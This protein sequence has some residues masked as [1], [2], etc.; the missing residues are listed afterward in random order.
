M[1]AL[2]DFLLGTSAAL[3]R[4]VLLRANVLGCCQPRR[5]ER[6]SLN[7]PSWPSG[8]S[9]P[10]RANFARLVEPDGLTRPA[11]S[12]QGDSR[13]APSN[14]CPAPDQRRLTQRTAPGPF[15]VFRERL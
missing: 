9:R 12:P 3:A 1:G 10:P 15:P 5:P 14:G 2:R 7:R 11:V 4:R 13:R 6:R 8:V